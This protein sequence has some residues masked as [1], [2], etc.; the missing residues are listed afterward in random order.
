MAESDLDPTADEGFTPLSPHQEA[1]VSALLAG[2]NE[3]APMLTADVVARLDAAIAAE[4]AAR[5]AAAPAQEAPAHAEAASAIEGAAIDAGS[6]FSETSTGTTRTSAAPESPATAPSRLANLSAAGAG[7][8]PP[9]RISAGAR[10]PRSKTL[11]ATA[12]SIA[13]LALLIGRPW[14]HD[15]GS[16]VATGPTTSASDAA[17]QQRGSATLATPRETMVQVSRH[18]YQRSS[19]AKDVAAFLSG[20]GNGS[21]IRASAAPKQWQAVT[22]CV[23]QTL[24]VLGAAVTSKV[25]LGWLDGKPSAIVVT[26]NSTTTADPATQ[27]IVLQSIDGRCTIAARTTL[28]R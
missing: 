3:P 17:A 20:Q 8:T 12:A 4:V 27:V 5:A 19:L 2:L 15:P 23:N 18:L 25:D 13:A 1:E 10:F 6:T 16:V 28:T 24:S 9:V 14:V 11:F 26:S 7:A 21:A 22:V